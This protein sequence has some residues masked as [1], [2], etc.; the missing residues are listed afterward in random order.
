MLKNDS[1][2]S[3]WYTLGRERQQVRKWCVYY[4]PYFIKYICACIY[5]C[6]EGQI[7]QLVISEVLHVFYIS[8]F[9]KLST[10]KVYYFIDK[11]IKSRLTLSLSYNCLKLS[12][13]FLYSKDYHSDQNLTGGNV[14]HL[15]NFLGY[16]MKWC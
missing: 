11:T 10:I 13:S 5:V 12:S 3:V 9:S 4:D 8:G 16:F 14:L 2:G 6:L 7:C 1:E 15:R